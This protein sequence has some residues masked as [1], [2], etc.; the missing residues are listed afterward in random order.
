MKRSTTFFPVLFL[1]LLSLTSGAQTTFNPSKVSYPR[2]MRVADSIMAM[3][4][5]I[6]ELP[7][8]LRNR[9]LPSQIDNSFQPFWRGILDQSNYY[10]CQQYAGVAYTFGYEINRLRQVPGYLPENSYPTH[11]SWNLMNDGERYQGVSF[12]QSFNLIRQQGHMTSVDFGSDTAFQQYGWV[13][14]YDHYF[15]GMTNRLKT[16]RAIPVNSEAGI[17]TLRNYLYDHLEGTSAGGVAC[18][19]TDSWSLIFMEPLPAGTPEAGKPVIVAWNVDPVHGLVVVGYNDSIRYDINADGQFTNNLDITGDGKVDAR[20]WEIGGFRIANSYGLWWADVGYC[21]AM[22]SAFAK[23]YGDGGIWNNRVYVVEAD[24]SYRPLLTMKFLLDYNS[25]ERIRIRAGIT[26]DT[27]RHEP[28]FTMDYPLFNFQG[29]DYSMQGFDTLTGS[30]LIEAGLDVTPLL[31][32]ATPGQPFKLFFIVEERDPWFS[33][34]G[35]IRNVSFIHHSGEVVEFISPLADIPVLNNENTF[36]PV[37]ANFDFGHPMVTTADLP[38]Y[39]PGQPWSTE[40]QAEGGRP[41]YTWSLIRRYNQSGTNPVFP[42]V[43]DRQLYPQSGAMPYEAVALP[44]SFPFYGKSYDTAWVNGLGLVTFEPEVYPVPYTTDE[45]AIL[46]KT[47]CISPACHT[48]YN[49]MPVTNDGIW[50]AEGEGFVTFRWKVSVLDY[51]STSENNFALRLYA[52]GRFEFFFGDITNENNVLTVYSGI[53]AGDDINNTIRSLWNFDSYSGKGVLYTPVNLPASLGLTPEGMLTLSQADSSMI[54][55]LTVRVTDQNGIFGEKDFQLSTGLTLTPVVSCGGDERMKFGIPASIAL[56]LKN[57]GLQPMQNLE[58]DLSVT[59]TEARLTDSIATLAFLGPGESTTIQ[60][61]FAASLTVPVPD[62]SPVG[63]TIRARAGNRQWQKPFHVS[64]SAPNL[65]ITPH[66]IADGDNHM[67]DPG[68]VTELVIPVRNTGSLAAG[69]LQL[70]L[71]C[72]DTLITIL[73]PSV[74]DI[75]AFGSGSKTDFRFLL[76]ASRYASPGVTVDMNVVLENGSDID[77][78]SS[79]ALPIGVKPVALLNLTTTSPSHA[80]M[81]DALNGLGVSFD[82]YYMMPF[83]YAGYKCIFTILGTATQGVHTL[84]ESEASHLAGYLFDGGNLYME[85]YATWYYTNTQSLHPMFRYVSERVPAWFYQSADGQ[86]QTF[87]G[88]LSFRYTAP[89]N[90]AIFDFEPKE[91][92]MSILKNTTAPFRTLEVAYDGTDYK[93]IGSLAEFGSLADTTEPSTRKTLMKR[94][95]EFFGLNMTGLY[96]L[97]HADNAMACTTVPV[98]FTDD[99]FDHVVSRQWEFPG[100]QPET[101]SAQN[102]VV[103]YTVPG[104]YDVRLTVSDGLHTQT[105]L[106]KEYIQAQ[107]CSGSIEVSDPLFRIYPNPAHAQVWIECTTPLLN[108]GFIELNDLTGRTILKQTWPSSAQNSRY[109]LNLPAG[110]SGLHI[111]KISSGNRFE[112]KKLI[113]N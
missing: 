86:D 14:G 19:T 68:E 98:T 85:G 24:T 77:I 62:N 7:D 63:F 20:D 21:Y 40:L 23:D 2:N 73:S 55:D 89:V 84:T 79:F 91:G 83:N 59:G 57:N 96:A 75:S 108:A 58:F 36:V 11:Y 69:N 88:D 71:E 22:Y 32:H 3:Q 47:V 42:T 105:I 113:L 72:S 37:V 6:L 111:L 5:P 104:I 106:R 90:Y 46:P 16:V 76:R 9:S 94:Y 25:R 66:T 10:T 45:M 64:A 53:S 4:I 87:A 31:S 38:G 26:T 81:A 101:S 29:G 49:Y 65:Q 41:S 15:N 100:G 80:A 35:V 17:L 109:L 78:S 28:D 43:T 103:A 93:T 70:R 27:L 54:Y 92:A 107:V 48:R 56:E 95:L 1:L 39:Q 110:R 61:A 12:L 18:F 34:N 52:D 112:V 99:S 44:F 51:E 67:L 60:Q 13:T 33:G 97:F 50:Y 102:P 30:S 82:T 74:I 8:H